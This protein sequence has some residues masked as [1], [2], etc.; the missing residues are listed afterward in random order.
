MKIKSLTI[1]HNGKPFHYKLL[2]PL[3]QEVVDR[4]VSA[5]YRDIEAMHQ[6]MERYEQD[7]RSLTTHTLLHITT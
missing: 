2:V 1:T 4:A 7:L 6:R 3:S 5:A